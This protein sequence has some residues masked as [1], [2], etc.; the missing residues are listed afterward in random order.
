MAINRLA[1]YT[2][3]TTDLAA[4]RKF[5]SEVLGFRVGYRPDFDFPGIW[6]Y[7]GDTDDAEY[8]TVHV[9]G[10]EPGKTKGLTDYLGE[11]SADASTGSGA[12]DHIAFVA[13]DLAQMRARLDRSGMKYFERTVPDLG[14]HQVFVKD[15]SGVTIELNYSSA[16]ARD[17]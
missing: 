12:L 5:Y 13:S 17:S 2:I 10:I 7:I 1:H 9:I 8:G 16:E 14:Q 4:T 15:P 6:L 3:R 11:K